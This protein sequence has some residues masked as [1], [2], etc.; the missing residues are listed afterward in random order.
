[1]S[2]P[3]PGALAVS[4]PPPPGAWPSLWA[5]VPPPSLLDPA[6]VVYATPGSAAAASYRLLRAWL[7][8]HGDPRVIALS[9]FHARAGT[10]RAAVN[11]AFALAEGRPRRVALVD[12][13]LEAPALAGLLGLRP[14]GLRAPPRSAYPPIEPGAGGPWIH[15]VD[16]TL[17]H[18]VGDRPGGHAILD[19]RLHLY[20]P[21]ASATLAVLPRLLSLLREQCD[22]VVVDLAPRVAWFPAVDVVLAVALAADGRLRFRAQHHPKECP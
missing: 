1:M 14:R 7:R 20:L 9:G 5:I 19:Q 13:H 12:G 8:R 15:A 3:R 18:S 6:L 17:G 22:R 11:L 2:S 4:Q 21:R 10:S 16:R